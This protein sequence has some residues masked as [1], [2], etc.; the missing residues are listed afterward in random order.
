MTPDQIIGSVVIL[1]IVAGG[2]FFGGLMMSA[3]YWAHRTKCREMDH[4]ER[5][6]AL[7]HRSKLLELP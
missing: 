6:A 2:G 1:A 7:Q 3:D 4:A 5:M